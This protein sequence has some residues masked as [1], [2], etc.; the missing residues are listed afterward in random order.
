MK[1]VQTFSAPMHL[2]MRMDEEIGGHRQ[3]SQWICDA[4]KN[5]IDGTESIKNCSTRRLI[6]ELLIRD[7]DEHLREELLRRMNES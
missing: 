3:K 5:K 7:I 1:V 4:I 2:V 6:A